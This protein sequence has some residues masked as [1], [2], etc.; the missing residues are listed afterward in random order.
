MI[1]KLK[2]DTDMKKYILL[3]VIAFLSIF[4]VL[5]SSLAWQ[6]RM[7]GM[8]D[9]YGLTNDDSDFLI[10]PSLITR[11]KGFDF[12]SNF[13]FRY[14]GISKWDMDIDLDG[15][16][17]IGAPP[18]TN[19]YSISESFDASGDQYDYK[20]LLGSAF[21]LGAGRMGVFFAYEGMNRDIDGDAVYPFDPSVLSD[22]STSADYDLESDIDDFSL[23]LIY[24]FPVDVN[25]L[26]LG[27]EAKISYVNEKQSSEWENNAGRSF[28][29]RPNVIIRNAWAANTLWFQVPYDSDYWQAEF[30]ASA[31]GQVCLDS[32]GPIDVT[33]SFG[34][35]PIFAGD[36]EY[37]YES[38]NVAVSGANLDADGDV[39]GF[40]LGG[41][42]WV[43]VP[44]SDTFALPFVVSV[45]YTEKIRD[46]EGQISTPFEF[47]VFRNPDFSYEQKEESFVINA[48][49]GVDMKLCNTSRETVGLFYTY[50]DS[51]DDLGITLDY[52]SGFPSAVYDEK[53]PGYTE[54]RVTLKLGWETDL[55]STATI[56]TGFSTFYG[57]IEKE[58]EFYLSYDAPL[59]I[60]LSE[61]DAASL[62]GH[63]WGIMA[64]IGGSFKFSSITLEPYVNAGYRDLDLDGDLDMD[65]FLFT[66]IPITIEMRGDIDESRQEWFV[67]GGLS[68]L[69][70]S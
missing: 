50:L 68:I 29:N 36:N 45:H 3:V 41:D 5:G 32:M 57:F 53:V 10:H 15:F 56:R 12:Y 6:G 33:L 51:S 65:A 14:T 62:D 1:K 27:A 44:V 31:N 66:P 35:G 28:L 17:G 38:E 23:R 4:F 20:A 2:K 49:G 34:G 42:L 37:R 52:P 40:N 18:P 61:R 60:P 24:G 69:F 54:H 55:S 48:G 64:S 19:P 70:G 21:S 26:N 47:P 43:R 11:G 46:G 30:K 13:D 8:G 39:S 9:P 22:S 16:N 58:Y 7:A 67:G 25:H 63:Q 59:P